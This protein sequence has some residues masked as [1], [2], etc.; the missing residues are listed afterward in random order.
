MKKPATFEVVINCDW[1]E[2]QIKRKD[3]INKVF[4]EITKLGVFNIIDE[5]EIPNN[6]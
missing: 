4:K 6:R 5:K 3:E 1:K 2:D